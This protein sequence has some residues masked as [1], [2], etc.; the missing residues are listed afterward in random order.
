MLQTLRIRNYALIDDV[1]V[2]FREGLNVLTG[3][4]GAG[5]SIVVG[6][7]NLVLGARA[8]GEAVRGGALQAQV[9][10]VFRVEKP[11]RRLARLLREHAIELEGNE[12]LVSRVVSAEGRSRAYAG[13]NLAPVSVLAAIG[14]ELVDLHGQHEHQSLLKPD[15]QLD[16]IDAYGGCAEAA[17]GVAERVAALRNVEREM[18]GLEADDR[19]RARRVDFLKFEVD[20]IDKAR[21]VPG[22]ED[23]LRAR[24]NLIANAEKIFSLAS[25]AH[26]LLYEGSDGNS[27]LDLLGRAAKLTEE[28][29]GVDERFK[30]VSAQLG[31]AIAEIE[32]VA[33]ELRGYSTELEFDPGE[34]DALNTRLSLIRDLK[35][36]Y[37]DA[38]EDILAYRERAVEE[39]RGYENR[40]ERLAELRARRDALEQNA[41][42][43]AADLSRARK[44]AAKRLDK[45]VTAA[46]QE[47]GM[48]GARFETAFEEVELCSDG[49]DRVE[50][51]LSANVGEGLKPLRQVASGGEVSRIMLAL[52]TAL[53]AADRIPTL[54]FDEI[55]AGVGGAV[56]NR[57][58][59]KLVALSASHQVICITHLPQIAAAA[60][61]HFHVAKETR[62]NKTL[63]HVRLVE[64]ES[65]VEEVARLLDGSVSKVSIAH[66]RELLR[67]KS[68]D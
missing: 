54:I 15:R 45:K 12:L 32:S 23:E 16:L 59:E 21:L 10:A 46:L 62:N 29:A 11:T 9:E 55:D 43:A 20:E 28:L 1:E 67:M 34:L 53:A 57:V 60:G 13:G 24:R 37:G 39:I 35:R 14:D 48:K 8:S 61:A 25:E 56:A 40:D 26:R 17:R 47:L 33:D 52:K 42:N 65:R 27:A 49:V 64:A 50:F 58:A 2:E 3:E 51:L 6:A 7:L 19:D 22:E 31:P 5:K 41:R 18:T 4:T 30:G 63:T 68:T 44:A 38:I 66:A 36:K